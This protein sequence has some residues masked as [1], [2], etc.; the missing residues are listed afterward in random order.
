MRTQNFSLTILTL[1]VLALITITSSGNAQDRQ[2]AT[3]GVTEIS[4][5]YRIQISLMYLTAKQEMQFLFL[6]SHLKL[7]I[8]LL[9][10]WN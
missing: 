7:V 1:V 3:K 8:L 5:V 6:L 10:V 4:G 2:F 9:M